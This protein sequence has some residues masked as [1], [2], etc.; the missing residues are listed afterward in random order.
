MTFN[1]PENLCILK[2][3][4]LLAKRFI[5]QKVKISQTCVNHRPYFKAFN[6]KPIQKT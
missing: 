1:V 3:S 4:H 6:Q 2:Y 5:S